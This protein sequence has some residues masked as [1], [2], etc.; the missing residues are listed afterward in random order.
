MSYQDYR[1][2][3][4]RAPIVQ[5]HIDYYLPLELDDEFTVTASLVWCEGARLNTEFELMRQDSE[6]ATT[7]YSVQMLLDGTTGETCLVSPDLL[8]RLRTRWKAGEFKCLQ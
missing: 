7:G 1:K 3:N 8:E 6:V 4:L 2:A 5:F